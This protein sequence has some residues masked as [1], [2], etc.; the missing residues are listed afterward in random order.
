MFLL[1][2]QTTQGLAGVW[3]A[4]Q[5][6][7]ISVL[8]GGA[9]TGLVLLSA[10][11]LGRRPEHQHLLLL[12]TIVLG[13]GTSIYL[14]ISVSIM[15]LPTIIMKMSSVFQMS[16]Q[17]KQQSINTKQQKSLSSSLNLRSRR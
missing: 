6:I 8:L 4:T 12:G 7:G 13:V 9:C 5:K 15:R 17:K 2:Y 16:Q 1:D 3:E 10:E 11:R 14:D